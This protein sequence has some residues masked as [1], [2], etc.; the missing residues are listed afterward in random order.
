MSVISLLN[1]V[2]E[3]DLV[4]PNIQR[5]V[6]WEPDAISRLMDSVMRG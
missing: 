6:V 4:L 1:R 3:G 2:R 5:S